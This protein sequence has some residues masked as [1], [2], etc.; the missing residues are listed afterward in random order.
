MDHVACLGECMIELVEQPDGRL[1]RGFGGD[2]LNTALYLARL[3]V[4]TQYVTAL[5]AD[6]F[7]DELLGAWRAERVG[8][9][10]VLR[11]PGRL[12]GL[13]MI[14]TDAAGERRFQYWRDSA[15]VR[16][17][18]DLPETPAIEAALLASG[19]IY[20]SGVT[21][22]LFGEAGRARLFDMLARARRSGTK[23]A[24]DT[25]FRPRGWPDRQAA[26]AVY[27]RMAGCADIVLASVE[28][29][30]LLDD[31]ADADALADRL[32]A[33]QVPEIVVKLTEPACRVI[34]GGVDAVVRGA[35]VADVIDTTAAGDSFSAA[36]IAA[37]R[38]G[39]APAAAA[40][41]GHRLAGIVVRHRGAIIPR[42]AM[43][44]PAAIL[45]G[46]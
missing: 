27:A 6:S 4:P 30:Q 5:G 16:Q 14:Q 24:F 2:T 37:R 19:L 22:S 34:A 8:T 26:R 9:D 13:Y 23:V 33:A 42:D 17:L 44:A 32:Q 41:A 10:A 45:E 25:N 28:D 21:L 35:A 43:P 36:Y 20:L 18:F 40:A 15:P 31:S 29:Y 7:S 3:G 12:P 38:G 39:A 46:P 1:T 11:L